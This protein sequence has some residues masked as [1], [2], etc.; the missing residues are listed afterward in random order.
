[1][2]SARLTVDVTPR[3]EWGP[4]GRDEVEF[5]FAPNSGLDPRALSKGASGGELSG[6]V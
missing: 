5:L 3:A 4:D 2:P 1:M 6:F